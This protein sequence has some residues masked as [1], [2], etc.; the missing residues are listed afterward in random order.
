ML[1]FDHAII[2][3]PDVRT[4]AGRLLDEH[5]LAA[6]PGGRHEQLGTANRIVPLGPDYLELMYVD[7]PRVAAGT[8]VGRWV[9]DQTAD[10]DRLAALLLRVDDIDSV[11]ERLDLA[12]SEVE[13][14]TS[15]GTRLS[16]H[17]AGLER[18]LG[19]RPLPAF[20]EPRVAPEHYPG[21]QPA[22]H[23]VEPR[24][25][26]WVEFGADPNELAAWL[27]PHELD[28]RAVETSAGLHRLAV[29]TNQGTIILSG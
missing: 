2:V 10:G 22:D 16:W 1:S 8:M 25:I 20:I 23:T 4:T 26:A 24:G 15:D 7:E 12:A 3:T 17:L 5:G 6:V 11:A 19:D 18:A 28:I 14:S 9:L 29:A 21:R 13:R 27:G